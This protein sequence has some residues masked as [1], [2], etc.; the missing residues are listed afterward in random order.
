MLG[1]SGE[2]PPSRSPKLCMDAII[3]SVG[4]E[5]NMLREHCEGPAGLYRA[6]G[7]QVKSRSFGK[8]DTNVNTDF[9]VGSGCYIPKTESTAP[10]T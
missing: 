6:R 4:C 9:S 7:F 8:W 3:R 10:G 2:Q 1:C 5:E